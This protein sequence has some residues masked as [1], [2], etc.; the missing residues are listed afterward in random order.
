MNN[1]IYVTFNGPAR[2]LCKHIRH[3]VRIFEL[4][5]NHQLQEKIETNKII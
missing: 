3:Y 5:Q 2:F 1:L 4:N